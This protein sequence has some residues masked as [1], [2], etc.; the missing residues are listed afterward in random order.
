MGRRASPRVLFGYFLHDAKSDNPFSLQR[1]SRFRKPRISPPQR[2]L[3]TATIK[4]FL[5]EIRGSANLESAHKDNTF[6]QTKLNPFETI[7]GSANLE[8][9]HPSNT[10]S[11]IQLNPFPLRGCFFRFAASFAACGGCF[12]PALRRS[13]VAAATFFAALRRHIKGPQP[14]RLRSFQTRFARPLCTIAVRIL[15]LPFPRVL[16]HI[17]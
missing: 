9:A 13:Y 2:H 1:T 15:R 5:R 17:L 3:R 16:A 8:S 10:F 4:T 14:S 6:V 12:F 7:R 11:L